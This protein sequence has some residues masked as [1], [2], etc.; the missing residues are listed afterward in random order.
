MKNFPFCRQSDSMMCGIACLQMICK[1][2]GQE[3]SQ[4]YLSGIC[5]ATVEGVSLLAVSDAAKRLHLFTVSGRVSLEKISSDALLPCILHWNQN[6]FVVLY[7][8]K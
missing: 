6:H 5:H 8:I 2:Y 7:K 1:Y 4:R 3:Y